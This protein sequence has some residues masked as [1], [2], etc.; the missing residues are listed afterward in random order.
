M[1]KTIL[2]EIKKEAEE[3]AIAHQTY[4]NYLHLNYLRNC[5]RVKDA[6]PKEIKVPEEWSVDKKFNPFYVLKHKDKI[7]KSIALKLLNK[8]YEPNKPFVK[9]IPKKGGGKRTINIYQ[10]PDSAVSDRFYYNLLSK[11]KHRFSSLSYAY[12]NDRNI[13]FGIQDIAHELTST[14]RIY[15][16]EFD[17]SDFFG[18]INHEYLFKQLEQNSFLVSDLEMHVIQSFLKPF[19]KGIPLGTSISLFLANVACWNLDRKFEDA[20]IRFAR[21]ADDTII[22]SRHYSKISAA[23]DIIVDFSKQ[24]GIKVN[25]NKS[26]G[27]SLLQQS[28]LRSELHNS[29]SFVE[30]LGYR[31]SCENVGIKEDAVHKIKK[32][33]SYLLYRNLIQPIQARPFKAM[34]IPANGLDKDFITA[35]MQVRRYLYGN[36]TEIT[37][38]KYLNGTYKRLSFKGIMSFYPLITDEKQMVEL[39]KWF[40]STVLNT[41]NKRKKILI[42]HNSNF[43]VNQF[44]FDCDKNDLI[45]KCRTTPIYGKKG[46]IELPSFM[47]IYKALKMGVTNEGIEKVMHPKSSIYYDE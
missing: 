13:H 26:D 47:R 25:Y 16:A 42:T 5:R 35:L 41:L 17:F 12:R 19:D 18:S 11:N 32:Q 40:L 33:V 27:I 28:G 20:G 37:L 29:K 38:K 39:D 3:K 46:L 14:P 45:E 21:Y 6:P 4:H 9:E 8:T 15:V 30:F 7:A 24:T 2:H 43:N 23:F 1:K 34:N 10:I 22:W 44:P 36:M 31:I